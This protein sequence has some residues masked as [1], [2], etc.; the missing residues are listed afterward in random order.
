MKKLEVRSNW[1]YW[2]A[3]DGKD[4]VDGEVL[5]FAWP[6]GTTTT[7]PVRVLQGTF[8]YSDMGH[9]STGPNHRAYVER[10]VLGQT[11]RIY[12]RPMQDKLRLERL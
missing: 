4:L 10:V 3:L 8:E 6:D 9:K 5:I 12:L 11:T 2:D 7:E 1:G